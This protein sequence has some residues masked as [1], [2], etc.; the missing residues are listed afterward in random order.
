M[1]GQMGIAAEVNAKNRFPPAGG[2]S[3]RFLPT[4]EVDLAV[5]QIPELKQVPGIEILGPLP[6]PYQ[7]VT[8]FVAAIERSSSK[9]ADARKL[10]DFLRT[11]GAAAVFRDKGLDP[12]L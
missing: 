10:I 11:P 4:G 2:L 9:A 6:S 8:V 1:L 5:Q 12:A 7:L 3:G